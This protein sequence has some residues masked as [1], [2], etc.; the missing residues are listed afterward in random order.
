MALGRVAYH[1]GHRMGVSGTMADGIQQTLGLHLY[2]VP[3]SRRF[4]FGYLQQPW[5][6]TILD[7]LG[8][9]AASME[10]IGLR[11]HLLSLL[12]GA[13]TLTKE[14]HLNPEDAR[15]SLQRKNGIVSTVFEAV[16]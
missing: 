11:D 10:S 3:R 1:R 15:M 5:V 16:G 13:A 9:R 2:Q 14:G 12:T 8:M 6:S 4:I 7:R